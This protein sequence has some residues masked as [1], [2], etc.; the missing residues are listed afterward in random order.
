[1]FLLDTNVISELRK[2]KPH[3]SVQEWFQQTPQALQLI[4]AVSFAEIQN[5]IEHSR[6]NDN[7]KAD[8]IERWADEIMAQAN[9]LPMTAAIFRDWAKLMVGRSQ[10]FAN[11]AMIAAT[12]IHHSLVVVT[13]NTANFEQFPVRSF[14]PFLGISYSGAAE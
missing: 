6:R 9:I 14:N 8:E 10:T 3:G 1:M 4:A 2:S 7:I 11:D 5:G 12:A 13:R